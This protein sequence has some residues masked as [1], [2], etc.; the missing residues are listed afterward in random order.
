MIFDRSWYNRLGVEYV[1]DFCDK[2]EYELFLEQC[3]RFENYVVSNGIILI[4]YFFD[5]SMEQ[6]EKR[7]L[8][9]INDPLRQ[10]KL[11]PMDLESYLRWWDYTAAYEKMIS[12]T[13]TDHAPWHVVKADDKKRARLNCIKHLLSSIPYHA[14]PFEKPEL[15]ERQSKK[16]KIISKITSEFYIPEV[17]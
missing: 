12:A 5:V 7:F 17:Y 15:P 9:R 4:K 11:S 10:W 14:A 2:H 16:N 1:M 3:P 13:N 8:N 6:Q